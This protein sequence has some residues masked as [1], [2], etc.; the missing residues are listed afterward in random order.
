M[1][2][3]LKV[4]DLWT[5]LRKVGSGAKFDVEAFEHELDEVEED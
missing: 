1:A 5:E 2:S 4:K 3:V